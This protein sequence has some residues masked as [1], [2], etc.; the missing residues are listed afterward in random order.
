MRDSTEHA[1]DRISQADAL[2]VAAGI[3]HSDGFLPR[4]DIEAWHLLN[5]PPVCPRCGAMARSS[6]LMFGDW[7]WRD[8]RQR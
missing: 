8:D 3:W 5:A 2:V 4:V 7:G 1:A 6:F